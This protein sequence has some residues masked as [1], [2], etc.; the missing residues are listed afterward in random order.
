MRILVIEDHQDLRQML[1]DGLQSQGFAV[2]AAGDGDEGWWYLANN[3]Y[4]T[5]ILDIGLPGINGLDLL[6]RIRHERA[7]HLPVLLLTA[8]DA[9]EDR[10]LGL[11]LGADDYLIKPFAAVELLAR[12]QALIRRAHGTGNP[13]VVIGTL[14]IDTIGRQVRRSGVTVELT[15]REYGVLELLARRSGQV[16]TKGELHDHVYDFDGDHDSNVMEVFI[17][18]LRRKLGQPILIHTRR[19]IGYLLSADPELAP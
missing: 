18:R 5:L 3:A 13:L 10:V 12:V 17:S 7:D 15:A 6:R 9:V 16:V 4:D 11:N 1:A 14:E 8:R 2:D 19:G